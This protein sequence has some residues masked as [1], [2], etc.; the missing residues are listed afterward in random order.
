MRKAVTRAILE[1]YLCRKGVVFSATYKGAQVGEVL[2]LWNHVP[3]Q[4]VILSFLDFSSA[5]HLLSFWLVGF[6]GRRL[7]E[8]LFHS[9]ENN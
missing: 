2:R 6:S 9:Y 1:E 5:L 7:G 3:Q 4:K 8:S